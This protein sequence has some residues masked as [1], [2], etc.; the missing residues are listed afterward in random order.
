MKKKMREMITETSVILFN[1][2]GSHK[3]TTNHIIAEL[4]ISPGTFYYHF[5]NK[6]EIIRDIFIRITEEFDEVMNSF[7]VNFSIENMV[8]SLKNMFSLYYRYRFFY[9]ELTS[10]LDRDNQLKALYTENASLKMESIRSLFAFLENQNIL[11][12]GFT[13]SGDF[14]YL[15][16]ILWITSDYWVSYLKTCGIINEKIVSEGCRN[17]LQILKPYM[18]GETA[19]II[20][21]YM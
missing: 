20:S 6:E 9:S 3:I 8:S 7:T 19:G 13:E 18:T 11:I 21:E 17:Y 4:N 16:D 14:R 12:R 15:F 10:L 2:N 5:K 1:Q